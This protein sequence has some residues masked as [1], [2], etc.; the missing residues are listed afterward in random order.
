[1]P[2]GSPV[3]NWFSTVVSVTY[4]TRKPIYLIYYVLS[5]LGIW[6]GSKSPIKSLSEK[7]K[8][9]MCSSFGYMFFFSCLVTHLSL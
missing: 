2:L 1:M 8:L 4:C 6:L 5:T 9:I 3:G 7:I